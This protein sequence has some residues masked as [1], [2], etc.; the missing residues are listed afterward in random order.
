M[1]S[2]GDN[3]AE[4]G[5]TSLFL[6]KVTKTNRPTG[7]DPLL[8]HQRISQD[9]RAEFA[10]FDKEHLADRSRTLPA[11]LNSFRI[12]LNPLASNKKRTG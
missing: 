8:L 6:L 4:R 3:P 12:K 7:N 5:K 11:G 2:P 9:D 10:K 1:I